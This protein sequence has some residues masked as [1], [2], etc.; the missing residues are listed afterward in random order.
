MKGIITSIFLMLLLFAVS[1]GQEPVNTTKKAIQEGQKVFINK[2]L[3]VYIWIST[4][5]DPNSEKFRL[6][7]DSSKQ[8]S[9]PMYFDTE[10]FNSFRTPSA[11]DTNTKKVVFPQVDII[12]DAYADGLPPV[13]HSTFTSKSNK[14]IDGKKYYGGNL[15][16]KINSK[17]AV[18]G[19]ESI[20]YSLNGSTF[21]VCN[22]PLIN[23]N[24]GENLIK[25]YGVDKVGNREE[26]KSETFYIDNLPPK[27][28][29]EIEGIINNNYVAPDAVIKL[30]S[31]DN[32][33]GVSS[34]FY[35]I[36]NGKVLKYL[37]PIP[38]SAIAD[39]K[40]NI[41]FYAED[42]LQNREES[43]IIGGKNNN[44]QIQGTSENVVFEFYVDND[45]P[46]IS[47]ELIGDSY[48]A[49][50]QYIS[51]RTGI[52]VIA[53]DEKSGVDKILYG[54]N[55]SVL[56]ENYKDPVNLKNEGLNIVRVK[57]IDFVGNTSP[58]LTNQFFCDI[59]SPSTNIS[60]GSPKFKSRDTLFISDKTPVKISSLDEH[61]GI[62]STIYSIDKKSEL[63]YTS[64]FN[65]SES[66]YHMINYYSIDR[67]NNKEE[68]KLLEVFVD[69]I[70]PVIH[71]NFSVESIGA[72]N[73]RDEKYTIYPSNAML[74]IATTDASSGGDKIEY[75]INNGPVLNANP[76]TAIKPGNYIVEVT[77]Y[78]VLGNKSSMEIKFAV[79]E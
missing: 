17:D 2:D 68:M 49:K 51:S 14:V 73:V 53:N 9:N 32:L 76:I 63:N 71:Y 57:A 24:E 55:S 75:K 77:A 74:Y 15:E 22:T 11:V 42:N 7:S 34:I 28:E 39:N 70:A 47:I 4:S 43:V 8:Y 52:K 46:A 6:F 33:S 26:I 23:F 20:M 45:P 19:M 65:I 21:A 60:V 58:L 67:V 13:S 72:K 30:K 25:Y 35:K 40:G 79:E 48:K 31:S 37:N 10:G 59:K 16:V 29:Y 64:G 78:D 56:N 44:L 69:N 12:F 27:T 66:G 62:S 41:T 3:G 18:S 61:S 5:P 38:V 50:N 36:G 1:F 54:I